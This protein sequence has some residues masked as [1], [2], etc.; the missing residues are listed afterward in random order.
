MRKIP[1]QQSADLI[2]NLP[3][4][5]H[6]CHFYRTQNDLLD[7]LVPYF[8][9]GLL[10]NEYCMWV[11]PRRSGAKDALLRMK[12]DVP[13]FNT[14]LD[15]GQID[16][17][18]ASDW[19]AKDGVF[20]SQRVLTGWIDRC[21]H[22]SALGYRGMRLSGDT[23]WLKKSTWKSFAD[24]EAELDKTMRKYP[25]TAICTYPLE[26]CRAVEVVDVVK[27]HGITLVK[28][29]KWEL[30]ENAERRRAEE[31]AREKALAELE[32]RVQQRTAELQEANRKLIAEIEEGNRVAE[33]LRILARYL[34]SVR[35]EERARISRE[36]HDEIG[37]GLTAIKLAL[38]RSKSGQPSGAATELTRALALANELIGRVRDLSM[39][40]RPPMLHDLGLFAALRWHFERYTDQFKITVDFKH[41]GLI[42]RRLTAEAET[43][44]YRIVQ[45]A[46]TNVA[47]HA[48][49]DKVTVEI[50]VAED[51]LSLRIKDEGI[52]FDLQSLPPETSGGLSG[53]RERAIILGGRLWFESA[54]GLGTILKAEIPLHKPV[55]LDDG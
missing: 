8:K 47:R 11:T 10:N 18:L 51:L 25:M 30:I 6:Y 42:D 16:F 39:Q 1:A 13:G 35:E 2:T 53:M 54:P 3:S 55:A 41:S 32:Q 45:E 19:Y 26:K 38:E 14:Y 12:R 36:L 22:A 40:L 48:K 52:G 31:E 5:T 17:L 33:R 15:E 4:G 46:L 23:L 20:N 9:R 7:L 24:Y 29:G 49:T 28:R 37:A 34:Q 27:N 21:N 44:V 43:A 50:E